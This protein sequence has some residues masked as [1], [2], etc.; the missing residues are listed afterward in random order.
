MLPKFNTIDAYL[1]TVSAE[2]RRALQRLRK[3][4]LTLFP[5]A[6]E[7]ISYRIP[8]FRSMHKPQPLGFS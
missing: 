7:C 1:K 2:R 5:Q 8:A 6:E 4:I 3:T